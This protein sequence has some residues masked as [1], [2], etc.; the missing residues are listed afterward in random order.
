MQAEEV[1]IGVAGGIGYYFKLFRGTGLTSYESQVGQS[2]Q[3]PIMQKRK[4]FQFVPSTAEAGKKMV[5]Q[6]GITK[7]SNFLRTQ[8][9]SKMASDIE[10]EK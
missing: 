6:G 9:I 7:N 10:E 5:F 4:D 1:Q 2:A 8:M 3:R